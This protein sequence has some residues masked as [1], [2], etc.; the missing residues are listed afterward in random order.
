MATAVQHGLLSLRGFNIFNLETEQGVMKNEMT[1][2]HLRQN[3]EVDKLV[4]ISCDHL[5][6]Q[7]G[8]PWPVMSQNGTQQRKYIEPCYLTSMGLPG[9]H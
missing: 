1:L 3:D 4:N 8:V 7:A 9:W 5:Q 6:L 2:S